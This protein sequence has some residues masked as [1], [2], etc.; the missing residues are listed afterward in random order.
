LRIDNHG[1]AILASY[2]APLSGWAVI[3]QSWRY[4]ISA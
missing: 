1:I 3:E 4:L 2:A